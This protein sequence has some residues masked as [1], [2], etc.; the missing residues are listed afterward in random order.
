[1]LTSPRIQDF[2]NAP[3]AQPLRV[4]VLVTKKLGDNAQVRAIADALG[5]PYELKSLEFTGVNHFHFRVFGPSLRHLAVDRSAPLTP[6]WPDLLLTIGRRSTPVALWIRQQSGGKTR[7]VQVGQSRVGFDCFDLVVGNPQ[8]HLPTQ[9]NLIRLGLPLL[10]GNA[11]ATD[12]V[13]PQWQPRFV[14][15]PRPWIALLVGGSA[16]PLV[17]D[18]EV[19]R[20][21]MDEV[22]RMVTR[23]GGSLLVTTSRR[24]SEKAADMIEAM[25]PANGFFHRWTPEGQSNPYPAILGL[26]DRFIVTG[27]SIS[28]LTEVVRRGKPLAI[29]PLP[30]RRKLSVRWWS[31]HQLPRLLFSLGEETP[32]SGGWRQR[33]G[34]LLVRLGLTQYPRDFSLFHEQLIARGVAVRFG[35]PFLSVQGPLPDDL[36]K[37]IERIQALFE[38][39]EG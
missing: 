29:Y 23:E 20:R 11:A 22:T 13:V 19:A 15:L 33:L 35:T 26:A 5:W 8:C 32:E 38:Q 27:E 3:Q 2:D 6:P 16:S 4:W 24:T 31:R 36:H 18:V 34:D 30:P 14:N 37:V 25:M 21:M 39:R 9:P 1:M 17:L 7:L 28:M 12:A 10:Y